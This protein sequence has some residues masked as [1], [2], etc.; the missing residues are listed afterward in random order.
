MTISPTSAAQ[1]AASSSS[2]NSSSGLTSLAGNFDTFLTLLTTQLKNQ[3]PT[4][5]V[6]SNQFTQQLVEFAGV[7][8]QVES[9]TLLKQ[10]VA[11]SQSGQVSNA[12]SFVG[13]TIKATGNQ[14]ALVSGSAKFGYTLP[15]GVSVASVTIKDSSGNTVFDGTGS[16]NTGD[17]VVTWDGKNS[18]TGAQE[19]DGVYTISVSAKDAGGNAVTVTPFITGKVTSASISNGSVVLDIGSLEVPEGNVTL[20]TNLPT[21]SSATSNS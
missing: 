18:Y 7:Q 4:S 12:A 3:D 1:Q 11:S 19:P 2:S 20:V 14:G 5:P 15:A 9:N 10:L 16:T 21:G 13:T 17:N 6:D 8:Q